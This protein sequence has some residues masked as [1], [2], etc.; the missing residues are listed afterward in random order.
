MIRAGI[1]SASAFSFAFRRIFRL[2]PIRK[3]SIS[4]LGP[5][6]VSYISPSSPF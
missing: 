1:P 5:F 3:W 4:G 6:G 2:L